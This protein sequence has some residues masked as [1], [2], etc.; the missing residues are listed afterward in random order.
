MQ[1]H[2]PDLHVIIRRDRDLQRQRDL[3]I[4]ASELRFVSVEADVVRGWRHAGRLVACGPQL[5]ALPVLHVEPRPPVIPRGICAPTG[6][7]EVAPT[8]EPA[9][10]GRNQQAVAPVGEVVDVVAWVRRWAPPTALRS[11]AAASA[12]LGRNHPAGGTQAARPS[13]RAPAAGDRRF[14]GAD[15]RGS[16]AASPRRAAVATSER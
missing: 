5:A 6:Q 15:P 2:A 14:A 12:G 10:R 3:V 4:G 1:G 8:A 13:A 7:V 16:A 9:A 11:P